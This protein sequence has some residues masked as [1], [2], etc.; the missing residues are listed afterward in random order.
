MFGKL[1]IILLALAAIISSFFTYYAWSWLQSIGAPA[2]A[3]EGFA[4]HAELAVG[5][6]WAAVVILLAAG[7]AVLWRS[8][9]SWAVWLSLAYFI[10]A[11][12]ALSFWLAPAYSQFLS[13]HNVTSASSITGPLFGVILIILMAIVVFFEQFIVV[14]LRA[15]THGIVSGD[16]NAAETDKPQDEALE[17]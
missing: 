7:N 9:R 2:A 10:I 1:Y 6:L 11:F 15:K 8:G 14:R 12:G 3:S 13:D 5:F 4:Y 16:D 17:E